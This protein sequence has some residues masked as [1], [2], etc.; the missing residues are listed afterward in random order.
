MGF[1]TATFGQFGPPSEYLD[2]EFSVPLPNLPCSAR[3]GFQPWHC[4]AEYRRGIRQYL[5]EFRSLN[6]LNCLDITGY[7]QYESIYLPIY[8]FLRS[9]NVDVQFGTRVKD[10]EMAEN[11]N[12]RTIAGLR[13]TKTDAN[14]ANL[15]EAKISLLLI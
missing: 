2:S 4:A 8:S 11:N 9:S 6:I 7:Y 1:L 5:A 14:H 3:F 10:I 13:V 12:Q 15:Y